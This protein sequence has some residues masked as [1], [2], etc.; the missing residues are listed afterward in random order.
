MLFWLYILAM[1][2]G[3]LLSIFSAYLYRK[4]NKLEYYSKSENDLNLIIV[5]CQFMWG[6]HLFFSPA[7]D[8]RVNMLEFN[9]SSIYVFCNTIFPIGKIITAIFGI[10]FLTIFLRKKYLERMPYPPNIEM[11]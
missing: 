1:F 11:K 5:L 7:D 8:K 6:W 3:F 9:S 4:T 10:V 2:I